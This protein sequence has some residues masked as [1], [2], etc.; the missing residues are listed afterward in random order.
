MDELIV[1][2]LQGEISEV[3]ERRLAE[4]RAGGTSRER[5][6]LEVSRLWELGRVLTHP[7][8]GEEV[9]S[10]RDL[11]ART[12]STAAPRGG[13]PLRPRGRS[14]RPLLYT[15]LAASLAA[16]GFFGRSL[17]APPAA[18]AGFGAA[19]FVTGPGEMVT[20]TLGDGSVVKLAPESRLRLRPAEGREVWLDGH[21]YFAVAKQPDHPFRI[22]THSGTAVVL[23]TRFDLQ[24]REGRLRLLVVEGKVELAAGGN[25]V[26]LEASELG[27]VVG[28]APLTESAV[29]PGELRDQLRWM[30]DFI[31]FE[32]TPLED[33]A[34][35]LSEHFGVPIQILDP[36]L[37]RET[38][39]G[40][41]SNRDL[42]HVLE[43]VCRAVN[44][45]CTV[46]PTGV[47]IGP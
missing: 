43:I 8:A 1:K 44:A 25:S 5:H 37:A 39:H 22:R 32:D 31:A 6:Y 46:L 21:A 42:N 40:W 7:S 33:A 23:G 11:V 19:E 29:A 27:E 35:E 2:S 24:A 15:A 47:T 3:E 36:D 28:D 17:L 34:R 26:E 41:F 13:A 38:V 10:T 18:P 4:W 20:V 14:F 30:G 16:A 9:P 45:H 12:D